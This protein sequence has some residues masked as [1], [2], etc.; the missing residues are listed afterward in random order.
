M[1]DSRSGNTR[2]NTDPGAVK[3]KTDVS[4]RLRIPPAAAALILA[5]CPA[6]AFCRSPAGVGKSVIRAIS[7]SQPSAPFESHG[8]LWF[9]TWADDGTVFVSW[10]DGYGPGFGAGTPFSHHG[11][12]RLRG[13]FPDVRAEVAR[14]FMPLSDDENNSKPTSL[15][16]HEGRLYAAVHSPLLFPRMGFTAY[17][18]D[19]GATFSYDPAGARTRERNPAFVCLI[20]VN[21]GKGS[22]AGPGG[23]VYAFGMPAEVN[24]SGEVYLARMPGDGILDEASWTYFAG[25]DAAGAPVWSG[26]PAEA[27]RIESLSSRRYSS[28]FP[29]MLFSAAYH[30]GIERYLVMTATTA[31]GRLYE[32]P[33]PWGV[34]RLAGKWFEGAG[35]EW[36]GAYMPG[37]ITKDMGADYFYFAAGGRTALDPAPGDEKYSFRLGKI[38]MVL[39]EAAGE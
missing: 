19:Y 10:G 5:L 16:F 35:S 30:P 31:E 8:D 29:N 26:N 33:A 20:F 39:E 34:W 38:T 4:R 32:A 14:R 2:L 27:E 28:L 13:V 36:Y 25:L 9:S 15:L 18:D 7:A 21:M 12:A 6:A 23:F 22:G 1:T 3:G 17:S 11:L 24:V 37:I